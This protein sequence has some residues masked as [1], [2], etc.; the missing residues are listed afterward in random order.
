MVFEKTRTGWGGYPPD[1]PGCGV[2]GRTLDQTKKLLNEAIVLH[3]KGLREDGIRV[4]RPRSLE[5][6]K[7]KRLL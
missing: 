4:P 7:R 6:L 5:T 2:T 1:L 3:Q